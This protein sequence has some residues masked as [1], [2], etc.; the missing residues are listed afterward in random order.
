M[1]LDSINEVIN[2]YCPLKNVSNS[3]KK[4]Q[5]KPWITSG[6]LKSI[7]VKNRLPMKMCRVKDI[8]RKTELKKKV[9]HYKNDLVKLTITSKV[10]HYNN[11]FKEWDGKWDS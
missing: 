10:N 11:F 6:I 7:A 9:K 4:S 5:S 1:F 8:I 3:Q 2:Y